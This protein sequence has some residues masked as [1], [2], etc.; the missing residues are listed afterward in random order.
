MG[1]FQPLKVKSTKMIPPLVFLTSHCLET[2]NQ[3]YGVGTPIP[4]YAYLYTSVVG[5][6]GVC[7]VLCS[8]R[9]SGGM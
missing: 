3:Y 9:T 5:V 8:P 7:P 6:G 1:G 4:N 2:Q